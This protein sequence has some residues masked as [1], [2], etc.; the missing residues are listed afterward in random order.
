M[1]YNEKANVDSKFDVVADIVPD[2]GNVHI[3][4]KVVVCGRF[5]LSSIL[6][7]LAHLRW[8]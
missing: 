7:S 4:V 5:L 3:K 1:V 6:P 8:F 2:K